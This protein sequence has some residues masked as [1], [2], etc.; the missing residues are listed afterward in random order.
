M[1]TA[2][3]LPAMSNHLPDYVLTNRA[4]WDKW[5]HWWVQPGER[6]WRSEPAWGIW[7]IPE[8]KLRLLPD[9]MA[10][11]DAIELGCGTGY[12]SAW[13][14]RRGARVV[15]VDNS[16]QQLATAAR[17][18]AEHGIDIEL[19]HGNAEKVPK[20]DESFDFAI[21]EYGVA[22]WADPFIWVPEAWRLLR[23]GGELVCLG[24]HPLT[25]ITQSHD[26]DDPVTREL[27]LPYF[28]MHRFD[29][30]DGEDRGVEFNLAISD[31]FKLF[32]DTGFDVLEYHE[33]QAPEP[34]SEVR[35]STSADWAHEFPS[36]QVWKVRKQL[37]G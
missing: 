34:G 26:A 1:K 30:D 25:M 15:G 28:G 27:L 23:P 11:M 24:N 18:A 12:V 3:I 20:P 32:A 17:L 36:E 6:G 37:S 2:R 21:S 4:H 19:I 35:F 9:D 29:W 14:V 31:W 10:G 7:Q 22:I 8:T 16:E 5:A 33:L 13:M